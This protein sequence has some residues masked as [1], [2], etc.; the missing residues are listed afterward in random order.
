MGWDQICRGHTARSPVTVCG[1]K[2]R[3]R[4]ASLE[5][6]TMMHLRGTWIWYK[7]QDEDTHLGTRMPEVTKLSDQTQGNGKGSAV[8]LYA[9]AGSLDIDT[10]EY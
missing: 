8:H 7:R 1:C 10:N 6:D 4:G 3:G 5:R 2:W 9:A